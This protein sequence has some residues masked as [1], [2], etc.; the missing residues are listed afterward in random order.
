MVYPVNHIYLLHFPKNNVQE[1]HITAWLLSRN[2]SSHLPFLKVF[3][4]PNSLISKR[5]KSLGWVSL[6]QPPAQ[7]R[8]LISTASIAD[9]CSVFCWLQ[10]YKTSNI[11]TEPYSANH[12]SKSQA[13]PSVQFKK[14]CKGKPCKSKARAF[15]NLEETP[16]FQKTLEAFLKKLGLPKKHQNRNSDVCTCCS[17]PQNIA[18][19]WKELRK[20]QKQEWKEAVK[21]R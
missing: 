1:L 21:K 16:R 5:T 8:H 4:V 3:K 11:W 18:Q 7:E 6:V 20:G 17:N 15:V 9:P 10:Q 13:L 2:T 19:Q 14:I 12:V